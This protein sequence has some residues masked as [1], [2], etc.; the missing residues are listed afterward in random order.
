[1]DGALEQSKNLT[2]LDTMTVKDLKRDI[3]SEVTLIPTKQKSTLG[4]FFGKKQKDNPPE[5][6]N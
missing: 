4:G 6:I 1:M 2:F 5:A 3:L